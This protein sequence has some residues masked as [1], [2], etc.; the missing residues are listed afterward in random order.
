[1]AGSIF[2][3]D[4]GVIL[5]ALVDILDHERNRR[6]GRNLLAAGFVGKYARKD[7]D[8]VRLLTLG[9]EA[10]LAGP[11]PVEI[12]LNVGLGQRNARRTTIDHA[13]DRRPMA[14]AEGRHAEG[15]PERIE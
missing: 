11:S 3:F 10:R 8:R 9:G 13:A 4:V 2:V 15:M 14:F 12:G 7:F 6:A 1:M 5:G